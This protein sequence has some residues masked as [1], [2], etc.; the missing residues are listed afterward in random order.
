MWKMGYKFEPAANGYTLTEYTVNW[1]E[2]KV[3]AIMHLNKKLTCKGGWVN[4]FALGGQV[5][6]AAEAADYFRPHFQEWID[7]DK[8][9]DPG[10]GATAATE[11]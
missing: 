4:F 5:M 2:V 8:L 11:S 6:D 9:A 7:D 10:A 1:G 3:N